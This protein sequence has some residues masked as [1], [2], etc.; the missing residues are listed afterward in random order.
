MNVT[1]L[2]CYFFADF[3]KA[4]DTVEHT[5]I[6]DILGKLNFGNDIINWIKLFYSDVKSCVSNNGYLSGADPGF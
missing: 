6:I 3:E 2:A 4:F 5:Y 1:H